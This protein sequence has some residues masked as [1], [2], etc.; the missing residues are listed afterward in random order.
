MS[1]SLSPAAGAAQADGAAPPSAL[2]ADPRPDVLW[3]GDAGSLPYNAR[4][5]LVRLVKGPYLDESRHPELWNALIAAQVPIRERLADLFLE[6]VID[7]DRAVAFVRNVSA[8][9]AQAPSVV[10]TQPL[11][12][13]DTVVVLHLRSLLVQARMRGEAVF[14]DREEIDA[15]VA[16]Y[17]SQASTD[18]AG[19]VRAVDA[20][21]NKMDN[22]GLLQRT[23]VEGRFSISPVLELVFGA[24]EVAAVAAQYRRLLDEDGGA[25]GNEGTEADEPDEAEEADDGDELA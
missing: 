16:V 25:R 20:S 11:T 17:R 24:D 13:T 2:E 14:V 6:L 15:A 19:F 10:R 21:V 5:A 22:A 4:R 23:A 3:E 8:P 7:L 9:E 1:S 18:E 12:F